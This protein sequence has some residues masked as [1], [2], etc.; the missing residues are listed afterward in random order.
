[1]RQ[2]L[3]AS[4]VTAVLG[5]A[6]APCAGPG[7]DTPGVEVA[8][9][10]DRTEHG[11]SASKAMSWADSTSGVPGRSQAG[12]ST[13]QDAENTRTAQQAPADPVLRHVPRPLHARLT[14]ARLANLQAIRAQDERQDAVFMKLGGSSIVS[15]A[16]L[17][18]F[19]SDRGLDLGTRSDLVETL[20]FFRKGNAGGTNPFRRESEAAKV[21]WS[22]RNGLV[23]RP[24][25]VLR[26]LRAVSPRF[27]LAF[28]GGNDVQ[29]R[30]PLRFGERMDHVISE[31]VARGVIPILGATTPRGDAEVMDLEARRQNVM[32]AGLAEAWG[33]PYI[34]FY[35]AL[36]G[37]PEDGLG[38]DGVHSN[39]Y[40]DP[41]GVP[42]PC[43]FDATGL[44]SGTN[45]RNLVTLEALDRLRRTVLEG[46]PAPD[47][48]LDPLPG[49]GTVEDPLRLAR[50]P[51]AE[52]QPVAALATE[53]SGYAC[54]DPTVRRRRRGQP[55]PKFAGEGPER[56][57]RV[58]IEQAP[59]PIRVYA[60]GR[61]DLQTRV[62]WLG[63]EPDPA[64][65]REV[66]DGGL[67]AVLEPGVHHLVVETAVGTRPDP[68]LILV[69]DLDP[70]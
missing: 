61:R 10:G 15:L 70:Q 62:V 33:I 23:G 22:A 51:Y 14:P 50:V 8:T 26:E 42:R 34:D 12:A 43:Q 65:C 49:A 63:A 32:A 47:A 2:V 54:D 5:L 35:A 17:H 66:G 60:L 16:Y 28:Y 1:M 30:D 21:G 25:R 27:A 52:R 67:V 20:S 3:I 9:G 41:N 57:L 11:T 18:C 31:L 24:S 38:H 6:L 45:V 68:E 64:S 48:P 13:A 53:L 44:A 58:V 4:S 7:A 69:V 46:A 55:M 36:E 19:A 29:A 40:F 39:V 56:V 37:L 59:V